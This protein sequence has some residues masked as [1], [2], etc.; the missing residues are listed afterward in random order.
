[1]STFNVHEWNHKRRLAAL[2][3]YSGE[4]P[5]RLK[6]QS[7]AIED[8]LRTIYNRL[9]QLVNKDGTFRSSV[10][11]NAPTTRS[12]EEQFNF[13]IDAI[14]KD[15]EGLNKVAYIDRS[16]ALRIANR[17]GNLTVPQILNLIRDILNE[18]KIAKIPEPVEEVELGRQGAVEIAREQTL[19]DLQDAIDRASEMG[20]I[21]KAEKFAF[22]QL[23][24]NAIKRR[25]KAR[26]DFE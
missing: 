25:A 18:G 7:P 4:G 5:Y 15:S 8:P 1:M 14:L 24:V 13:W 19:H 17:I 2:N 6:F 23:L 16:R 20:S 22:D 3:E 10:S 9:T 26:G 12:A 21:G 11:A